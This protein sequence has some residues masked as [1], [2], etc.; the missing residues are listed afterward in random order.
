MKIWFVSYRALS[1]FEAEAH[2]ILFIY[3]T[4]D[5]TKRRSRLK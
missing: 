2:Q 4:V 3:D 5:S 1:H